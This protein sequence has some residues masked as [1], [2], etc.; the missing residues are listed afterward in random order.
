MIR[1]PFKFDLN[2][3]FVSLKGTVSLQGEDL[4]IETSKAVLDMIPYGKETFYIPADEIESVEV[5]TGLVKHRFVV[6]PFSFDVLD[7]F[8]GDPAEEISLP[9]ARKHRDA[10]EA[11]A[12]ETRLRNLPR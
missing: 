5:E 7:G 4:V 3:G 9:I 10:A 11:L 6:R 2:D 12:R 1:I 8:P